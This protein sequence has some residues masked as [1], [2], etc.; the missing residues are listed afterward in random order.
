MGQDFCRDRFSFYR[1]KVGAKMDIQE[2]AY[3]D[4]FSLCYNNSKIGPHKSCH[5]KI[6]ICR[7]I[8]QLEH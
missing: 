2:N 1:D 4:I 3:R 5:D 7:N 6:S 8:I